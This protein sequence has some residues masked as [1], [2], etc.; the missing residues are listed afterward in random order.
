MKY[1]TVLVSIESIGLMICVF[2]LEEVVN[3]LI[4]SVIPHA[5]VGVLPHHVIDGVHD[6]CH[7]LDR[8]RRREE[9]KNESRG[10]DIRR[11]EEERV[12]HVP[13]L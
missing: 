3:V 9:N 11:R 1:E 2:Y 7:L 5:G 13:L 10:A 4:G 8:E 12:V 6:V